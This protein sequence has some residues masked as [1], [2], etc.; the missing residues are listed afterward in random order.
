MTIGPPRTTAA[1]VGQPGGVG[2]GLMEAIYWHRTD[3]Q[4]EG[5][6]AAALLETFEDE[7]LSTCEAC[8]TSVM[9]P[10]APLPPLQHQLRHQYQ[11]GH[12]SCQHQRNSNVLSPA[13]GKGATENWTFL[14]YLWRC[15][16][17]RSGVIPSMMRTSSCSSARQERM[18]RPCSGGDGPE[19]CLQPVIPG[20][21]G[22]AGAGSAGAAGAGSAG[23]AGAAGSGSAV[24]AGSGS[25][26]AAGAA[27]AGSAGCAG[28]AGSGSAGAGSAGSAG[29]AGSGSAGAAG[30]GSAGAAGSSSAGAAGA[31]SAGSAGAGSVG[32]AGIAEA[33]SAGSTGAAEAGSA[34]S[35][36]AAEA[37]SAGSAGVAGAGSGQPASVSESTSHRLEIYRC[38]SYN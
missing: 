6:S 17:R 31:G 29:A 11:L 27:G 24:A 37:G 38:W 28:A 26:G 15:R 12:R 4:Q 36:G 1:G 23:S 8:S 30:S 21:A 2:R 10:P 33:G 22:A 19:C 20:C 14:A 7:S 32:S 16:L 25:A 13:R 5:D 34:E 9:E 35:A 18:R 3:K